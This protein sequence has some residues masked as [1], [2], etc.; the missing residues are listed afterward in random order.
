MSAAVL[1]LVLCAGLGIGM[2]GIGGVLVV[3]GLSALEGVPLTRAVPAS[4]LAF[5]FTGIVATLTTVSAAPPDERS[6]M[7][8]PPKER[9][10]VFAT[11]SALVRTWTQTRP[12]IVQ[13]T[14]STFDC[15]REIGRTAIH[16][17]P[18]RVGNHSA[19]EPL[20]PRRRGCPGRPVVLVWFET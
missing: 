6:Q 8:R 18:R 13:P 14:N 7:S 16:G 15:L 11:A 4:T 10:I 17:A 2:T 20:R 9:P 12:Y 5:L 19:K 3:P 1:A